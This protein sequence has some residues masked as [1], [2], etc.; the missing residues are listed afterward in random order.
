M[1]SWRVRRPFELSGSA[2]GLNLI[3]DGNECGKIESGESIELPISN[4]DH[5]IH[6]RL[7]GEHFPDTHIPAGKGDCIATIHAPGFF[8]HA[9]FSVEIEALPELGGVGHVDVYSALTT[10]KL[11]TEVYKLLFFNGHTTSSLYRA[12]SRGQTYVA[13]FTYGPTSLSVAVYEPAAK[14]QVTTYEMKYSALRPRGEEGNPRYF[15]RLTQERE[16]QLMAYQLAETL[17]NNR[18]FAHLK[19]TYSARTVQVELR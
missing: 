7:W 6:V 15:D 16:Q 1:R 8:S 12:R 3:L 14:R 18:E 2:S 13:N 10:A 17:H 9:Y 11:N 19:V 4:D 5:Y